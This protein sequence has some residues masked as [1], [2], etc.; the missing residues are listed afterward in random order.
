MLFQS[1]TMPSDLGDMTEDDFRRALLGEDVAYHISHGL[2][3][4][5][6]HT[7]N[8]A[9]RITPERKASLLEA[10]WHLGPTV[11][12]LFH[13]V[14][15]TALAK[16][17]LVG[18]RELVHFWGSDTEIRSSLRDPHK[19]SQAHRYARWLRNACHNIALRHDIE[20][21]ALSG[22]LKDVNAGGHDG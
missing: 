8:S 16:Q 4:L 2:A 9:S 12:E 17:G 10:L 13:D 6:A 7:G 5:Q 14:C 18:A 3:S 1:L 20:A 21:Y 19:I 22:G 11:G 15:D